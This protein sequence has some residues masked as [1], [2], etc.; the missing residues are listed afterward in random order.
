L[1]GGG[2]LD[3][4]DRKQPK[5]LGPLFQC[6][7][8]SSSEEEDINVEEDQEEIDQEEIKIAEAQEKP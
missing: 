8:P 6:L 7:Y 4:I 3:G 1:E 2:V 5:N